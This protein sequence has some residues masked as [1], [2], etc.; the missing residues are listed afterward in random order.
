ML[1]DITL[2]QYY[3]TDSLMH[4][5]DPRFKIRF[6]IIYIIVSLF[7]RNLPFFLL[8]SA[9]CALEV[10]LSRVPIGHI[11]KG[12]R[13]IIVF[14]FVCSALN[15]FTVRGESL[16]T[17]G[18]LHITRE[19][20]LKA[21][22]VFWRM[23]MLIVVASLLTYTTTPTE[24]TD[25]LE[26]CF[27][28]SA[29]VAVGITI[30]LRFVSVLSEELSRIMRAQEARGATFHKGGPITRLKKLKTVIVPLFQNAINRAGNLGDAM[31]ARCYTG[32]KGRTK[33]KPLK[34]DMIDLIGYLCIIIFV[35]LSI[36]LILHF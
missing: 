15:I 22:F 17:L 2:G 5:L 14:I 28:L 31:D 26:K 34:Y 6:T 3:S 19:G 10:I 20:L 30:A 13:G 35:A 7:D 8:L 4:R 32:G 29:G 1:R 23:L 16:I 12:M 27:H 24:L 36:W 18:A 9:V 25:S 11:L 33:L 21:G